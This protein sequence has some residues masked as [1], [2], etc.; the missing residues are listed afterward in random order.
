MQSIEKIQKQAQEILKTQFVLIKQLI[1]VQTTGEYDNLQKIIDISKQNQ[2]QIQVLQKEQHITVLEI[3]LLQEDKKEYNMVLKNLKNK[4]SQEIA[5]LNQDIVQLKDSFQISLNNLQSKWQSKCD[6]QQKIYKKDQELFKNLQKKI[7][8]LSQKIASAQNLEEQEIMQSYQQLVNEAKDQDYDLI[9]EQKQ[10]LI[11]NQKNQLEKLK[12]FQ[13]EQKQKKNDTLQLEQAKKL[14]QLQ[15]QQKLELENIDKILK[16]K[17]NQILLIEKEKREEEKKLLIKQ[18][19]QEKAL[20]AKKEPKKQKINN[21][22]DINLID[23]D[24]DILEIDLIWKGCRP[25]SPSKIFFCPQNI[26]R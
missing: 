19:E 16:E 23:K 2:E 8:I 11:K 15:E 5:K 9:K 25:L 12:K 24:V 17:E 1:E 18:K 13:S 10:K 26:P 20:S 3:Q 21:I 4:H 6:D 7:V 22:K 14:N